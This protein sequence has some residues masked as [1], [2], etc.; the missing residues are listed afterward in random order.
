MVPIER[1]TEEME[2]RLHEAKTARDEGQRRE[3]F[4]AIRSL[5]EVAL[6]GRPQSRMPEVKPMPL[7]G[8]QPLPGVQPVPQA[9]PKR[10]EDGANGDSIFD[11]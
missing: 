7:S 2:R 1:I 3:A 4:A 5:A 9:A 10:E 11:F 8:P 6:G